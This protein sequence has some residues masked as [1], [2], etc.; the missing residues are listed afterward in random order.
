MSNDLKNKI[1][2]RPLE[3]QKFITES[4]SEREHTPRE[5]TMVSHSSKRTEVLSPMQAAVQQIRNEESA[6][7]FERSL[8]TAST[9]TMEF[10]LEK[11]DL[12]KVSGTKK[13]FLVTR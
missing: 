8:S 13:A 6:R 2:A 7:P 5:Q 12:T 1:L 9:S 10:D 4:L 3:A 11:Q